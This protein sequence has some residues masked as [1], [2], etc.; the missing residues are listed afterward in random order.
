MS[1]P[2]PAIAAVLS[3]LFPGLGQAYAGAVRRGI[4]WA[5]PTIVLL[6]AVLIVLRGGSSGLM[7]MFVR[8]DT[9]L[10][11]LVLNVALFFYHLAA[12]LDAYGV[13]HR[14]HRVSSGGVPRGGPVALAVVALL[15]LALH[16]VPEAFAIATNDALED[17]AGGRDD[18]R[19]SA[20]FAPHEPDTAKLSPSP[21]PTETPSPPTSTGSTPPP[22]AGGS[23]AAGGSPPVGPAG[24]PTSRPESYPPIN[25]AWAENGRLDL[26]LIG[27]DAGPGRSSLRTDTMIL[28]SVEIST[29]K[30]AFFGFPR[31]M[32]NVPLHSESAAAYPGGRFPEM[33]SALWR[34]AME[35]PDRFPGDDEVRG[36]RAIA[37]AI[38]E[39]AGVPLDGVVGVDLNGFVQLVDAVGGVW[40][41]V[42]ARVYDP[43]YP[44]EDGGNIEI[45]IEAG[46]QK[47]DGRHALAYARSRDQ[48]SDYQRMKRQQ[49]VLQAV[50]RQFD[51]VAMV[52]R[53]L[54]LLDIAR[55]N[56]FTDIDRN[57]IPQMAEVASRVDPDRMYQVR[58][59]PRAYPVVVDDA[60][61]GR[62]RDKV[63]NI[64]SEPEPAPTASP[65]DGQGERC[66]PR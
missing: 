41:D 56:L 27:G 23:P 58:F 21:G 31:N 20:S 44:L 64:F 50:R 39:L 29:G 25:A 8:A 35:Q 52:P 40:I 32:T 47:L 51:P 61:I 43:S 10:A 3:F 59:G 49:W 66:P 37:G 22:G 14:Q 33:L 38:Q 57:E 45:E 28:L 55:D 7:N 42:P 36:W 30:A 48:D 17:V 6:L 46:C 16:G 1:S 11:V 60:A 34:R 9:L 13:A 53:A 12:V 5:I 63:R 26:L 24:S 4:L 19:P 54:E 62:I 15:T 2:S 18:V 65:R